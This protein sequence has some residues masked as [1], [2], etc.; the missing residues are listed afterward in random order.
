MR[1]LVVRNIVQI[2]DNLSTC[3]GYL[4]FL[5]CNYFEYYK[6]IFLRVVIPIRQ[7]IEDHGEH[8]HA[9]GPDVGC[10]AGVL[11]DVGI[12]GLRWEEVVRART[13]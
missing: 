13:L 6:F 7:L 4:Q 9:D 10:L 2:A 5:L 11:V 1:H 12:A 3:F 8:G